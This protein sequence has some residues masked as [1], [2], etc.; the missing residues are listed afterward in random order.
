MVE[1]WP[2]V[3][4]LPMWFLKEGLSEKLS[5]EQR[6][7]GPEGASQVTAAPVKDCSPL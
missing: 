4:L 7:E 1:A 5:A 3:G 6:S 2:S